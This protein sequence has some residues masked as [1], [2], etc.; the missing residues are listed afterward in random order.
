[1]AKAYILGNNT[2]LNKDGYGEYA[3]KVPETVK[4]HGG[5][6]LARGGDTV[7]L[8]GDPAGNRN[9]IIEF[10]SIDTAK[11]W[12]FSREYQEIV[13]GRLQNA[14]GYLLIVEGVEGS[15]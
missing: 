12:Y 11:A 13:H 2:I 7:I 15:N 8:D 4:A 9:V 3:K 6:F 14:E 10:P 1:M 5:K